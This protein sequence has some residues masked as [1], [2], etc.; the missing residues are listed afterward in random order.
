MLKKSLRLGVSLV[1]NET[2]ERR[3]GGDRARG[4]EGAAKDVGTDPGSQ[5]PSERGEAPGAVAGAGRLRRRE[6]DKLW[7]QVS[8]LRREPRLCVLGRKHRETLR[9]I[10]ETQRAERAIHRNIDPTAHP[11]QRHLLQHVRR[12]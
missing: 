12:R 7:E 4:L 11:L 10:E 5:S 6:Q 2:L 3:L 1:S 8:K 9:E